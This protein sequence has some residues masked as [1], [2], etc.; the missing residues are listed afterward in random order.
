MTEKKNRIK[1]KTLA[2]VAK[3]PGIIEWLQHVNLKMSACRIG[4][5]EKDMAAAKD[6]LIFSLMESDQFKKNHF[7]LNKN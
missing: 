3:L 5:T 6:F 4:S 2:V 7:T 1:E